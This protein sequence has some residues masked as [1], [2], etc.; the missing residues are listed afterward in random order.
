MLYITM[1]MIIIII[2]KMITMM[3]IYEDSYLVVHVLYFGLAG[4]LS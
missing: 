3:E 2:I 4:L 1:V